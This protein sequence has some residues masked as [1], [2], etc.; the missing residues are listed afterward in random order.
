[1]K[2]WIATIVLLFNFGLFASAQQSTSQKAVIKTPGLHCDYCKKRVENYVARQYG[3][4][5][6]VADLKTKTTTVTWIKD[7]A[8]IEDVKTHIANV[9]YD[10]DDVEAEESMYHRLPKACQT[11]QVE[12]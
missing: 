11:K 6:V 12:Q 9:G 8:N 5:A 10:A 2:H 1:M 4:L 3:I 7:R